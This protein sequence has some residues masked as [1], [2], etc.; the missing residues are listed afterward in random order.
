MRKLVIISAI[1]LSNTVIGQDTIQTLSIKEVSV[2]ATRADENTPMT[3]SFISKEE[4]G[5]RNLG[6]DLPSLLRFTPSIVT[7]SDAGTGI[8]YTKMRIR[9]SDASRINVT[10]NGIPL[11]DPESHGVFWVNVPDLSS[12][13]NSIQ[14]QR[15]V[16]T[17]SN[18][19][20]AFGATVNLKTNNFSKKSYFQTDNSVGSFNTIKNNINYNSGILNQRYNFEV[21]L[22]RISSD[23]YIDGSSA[24]LK[25][26]FFF[27]RLLG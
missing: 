23:G 3:Y 5:K 1:L 25:S 17:S 7:S 10:I 26:Y 14:I 6:Q 24:K 12:S 27:R 18:G 20:G 21:R 4:I 13:L 8:G 9:G 15:G 16:G 2:Y 22:S 19:A 11:N